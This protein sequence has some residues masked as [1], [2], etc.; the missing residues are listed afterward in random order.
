MSLS[1]NGDVRAKT[2]FNPPSGFCYYASTNTGGVFLERREGSSRVSEGELT[3]PAV[4][5][6][7]EARWANCGGFGEVTQLSAD[8][9]TLLVS[10]GAERTYAAERCAAFVY[11]HGAHGWTLEATLFPPGIGAAGTKTTEGCDWFGTQGQISDDGNHIA[12]MGNHDVYMFVREPS[13]WSLEQQ[14]ALP[15][16]QHCNGT[17]G[18]K[19]LAFSGDASTLLVG[20]PDCE[21]HGY[22]GDGS[23]YAYTHSG[24][25]WSLSQ[26]IEAPEPGDQ[27]NFGNVVSVS[28]DGSTAAISSRRNLAGDPA[29]A[30]IYERGSTGWRERARLSNP[31]TLEGA[32]FDCPAIVAG[33][34]RIVCGA[35]DAVGSNAE[36]GSIYAFERP[37]GGWGSSNPSLVRLFASDGFPRDLLG[38]SDGPGSQGFGVSAD[39]SVIDAPI[40]AYNIANGL[41]PDAIIGYEFAGPAVYSEP[42][43]LPP[44]RPPKAWQARR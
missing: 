21:T 43:D 30:R 41:Y 22:F 28:E 42:H 35:Y 44:S 31:T 17:I 40:S 27:D 7:S 1:A 39:G 34:A 38:R 15:E 16:G 18:V 6:E 36:Q 20:K 25:G 23:V 4:G 33:G 32:A 11:G 24:S 5:S 29:A 12:V 19:T 3:A 8:G 10:Q 9:S 37:A 2:V 26:T 13:G 14:I